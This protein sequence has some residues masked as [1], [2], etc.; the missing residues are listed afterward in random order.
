MRQPSSMILKSLFL[1]A[2]DGTGLELLWGG[3]V[4]DGDGDVTRIFGWY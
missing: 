1:S 4:G 3:I 2:S